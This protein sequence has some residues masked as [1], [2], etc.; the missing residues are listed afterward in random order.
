MPTGVN[1]KRVYTVTVEDKSI[2]SLYDNLA[3]LL[4]AGLPRSA[5]ISNTPET[6]V[7]EVTDQA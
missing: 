5:V 3:K 4:A 7:I 6:I 1:A 2:G